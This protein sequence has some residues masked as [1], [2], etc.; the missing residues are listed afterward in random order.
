MAKNMSKTAYRNAID[1][2]GLSQVKASEF[3]EVSRKTSPRWARGEAPIPGAVKKLL[4]VMIHEKLSP[5]EVD[6]LE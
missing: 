3:F 5:E 4:R 6:K 2:V 1:A